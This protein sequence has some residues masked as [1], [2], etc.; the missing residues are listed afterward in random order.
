MRRSTTNTCLEL[1]STYLVAFFVVLLVN[2]PQYHFFSTALAAYLLVLVGVP[3]A[4]SRL[5]G[6]KFSSRYGLVGVATFP[7]HVY[8]MVY[9]VPAFVVFLI[10]DVAQALSAAFA[11]VV[12]PLA[13]EVF[14]RGYIA[15]RL[16]NLGTLRAS[17]ISSILFSA[18]HFGTIQDPL[19]LV[20]FFLFGLVYAEV[21]FVTGTIYATISI[22][23]AWNM[24]ATINS[25]P[26][27]VALLGYL[28]LLVIV[29]LIIVNVALALLELFRAQR[30]TISRVAP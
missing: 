15:Q 21:F 30:R 19:Y 22:H 3:L 18:F 13:E 24:L 6:E 28:S 14:F 1:S 23:A 9:F 10:W 8:T 11:V 29:A 2:I 16:G 26:T 17:I 5:R 12:A 27:S 20:I 4:S 7:W 25:S